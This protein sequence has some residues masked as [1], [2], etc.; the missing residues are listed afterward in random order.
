[1]SG[2]TGQGWGAKRDL[3]AASLRDLLPP[4]AAASV[5]IADQETGLFPEEAMHIARAVP[6]RKAEFAAGRQAARCALSQL[7][8]DNVAIPVGPDREPCWPAGYIGSISHA[9]GLCCGV[10][11]RV[12]EVRAVGIDIERV[13][14]VNPAV[15]HL[16][17][18][19]HEQKERDALRETS[20][21]DWSTVTFSAKEA[22]FKC[23]FPHVRV[24]LDFKDVRLHLPKS[25]EEVALPL[26]LTLN[27]QRFRGSGT[28]R[29]AVRWCSSSGLVLT[30]CVMTS[31]DL[32][33]LNA[34]L[35]AAD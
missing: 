2:V 13:S 20:P 33:V 1:M 31:E 15:E 21:V 19:E 34:V 28:F 12:S 11:A 25:S 32:A 7:G 3:I 9:D 22:F 26:P 4:Q 18:D 16:I 29:L 23:Y 24:R 5:T 27:E 35:R 30:A 6:S 10:S 14:A 17:F 8:C